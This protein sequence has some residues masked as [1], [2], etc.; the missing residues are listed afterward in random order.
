MVHLYDSEFFNTK[1]TQFDNDHIQIDFSSITFERG[2]VKNEEDFL[3]S[4]KRS[5]LDSRTFSVDSSLDSDLISSERTYSSA[6]RT[7]RGVYSVARSNTWDWFCTF[8][9]DN[10]VIDRSDFDLCKKK[11]SKFW[12]NLR[13]KYP[14]LKYCFIVEMHKNLQGFHYHGVIS[15]L[16]EDEFKYFRK[17]RG[18]FNRSQGKYNYYPSW[19][20]NSYKLGFNSCT[21]VEYQGKV[22]TYVCKYI[23]KTAFLQ[24]RLSEKFKHLYFHSNNLNLPEIRRVC[25]DTKKID[26]YKFIEDNFPDFE[27]VYNKVAKCHYN[28]SWVDYIQLVRKKEG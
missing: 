11:F 24:N 13:R 23:T 7:K 21:K 28:G 5:L 9:F 18:S 17:V 25:I 2:K 20:M 8:T 1:I 19:N 14:D 10:K 15:G 16:P 4:N 22:L 3:Q 27:V 12:N 26:V 6:S